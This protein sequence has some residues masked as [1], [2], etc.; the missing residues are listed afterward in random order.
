MDFGL[1]VEAAGPENRQVVVHVGRA[2]PHYDVV[3]EGATMEPVARLM[4]IL[5][6]PIRNPYRRKTR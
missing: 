2:A 5:S 1:Q 6:E 3:L 4:S